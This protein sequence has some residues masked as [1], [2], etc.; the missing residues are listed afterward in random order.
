MGPSGSGPKKGQNWTPM[1]PKGPPLDPKGPPL[2]PKGPP[3]AQRV[4]LEAEG[5]LKGTLAA[6]PIGGG[7][8]G[9]SFSVKESHG[10]L[11]VLLDG[12]RDFL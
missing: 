7:A 9:S 12:W 11:C 10:T 4:H 8:I 3:W 6:I 5:R 1:V 2:G